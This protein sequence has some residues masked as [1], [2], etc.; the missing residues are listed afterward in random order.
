LNFVRTKLLICLVLGTDSSYNA[1]IVIK[2]LTR[3]DFL[4]A[5][6]GT[7]AGS[8]IATRS[9]AGFLEPQRAFEF[10]V[11]G[12]S[13]VWGQG[14]LERDKFYTLTAEWMRTEV[15]GGR[16]PVNLNVEAHSGATLKFHPDE[17][18]KYKKAGRDESIKFKP[19]VNVGFPSTY[20]QIEVAAEEYRAAGSPGADLIMITGGI[21]DISTSV[22]YDPKGNDDKLRADIKKYC[23]DDMYDV[24]ERAAQLHPN[25]L[26]AVVGYFPAISPQSKDAKLMNA[27]L[28]VL[29]TNGFKKALMN[30]AIVRKLVF[31]T[32]KKRSIERS[33]IWVSESSK[34]SSAA[35]DKL[36]SALGR[37]RAI[38][39]EGPLTDADAAETPNTKLWRMGK[40][41]VVEDAMAQSRIKDCNDALPKLKAETGIDYPVRLCEAAAVGHPN[42]AGARAYA[43][44]IKTALS[45]M[46]K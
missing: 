39:V 6:G 11:A 21:T 44:A 45:P 9:F 15:F 26:I 46:I 40:H 5:L 31:G 34:Q 3:R 33:R 7:V 27:W 25:A 10:L 28:E 43:E 2:N 38:F 41:G 8:A 29:D 13:L 35:V 32:L 4:K 1:H 14:L 17:A 16:R 19:E 22:V 42:P 12:D 37:K 23:F 36:N 30:N 24:I 18:A 20:K